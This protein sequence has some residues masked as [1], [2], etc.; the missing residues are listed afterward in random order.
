MRFSADSKLLRAAVRAVSVAAA[1][2][3]SKSIFEAVRLT[4]VVDGGV[5]LEATDLELAAVQSLRCEVSDAGACA[6]SVQALGAALKGL[7]GEVVGRLDGARLIIA[8]A[9]LTVEDVSA[10]PEVPAPPSSW[11]EVP[12]L[13]ARLAEA[14]VSCGREAARFV[15]NGIRLEDRYVIATDARRMYRAEVLD[16]GGR[17]IVSARLGKVAEEADGIAFEPMRV[18]LRV[19]GGYYAAREMEGQYPDHQQLVLGGDRAAWEVDAHALVEAC[20]SA[21]RMLKGARYEAVRLTMNVACEVRASGPAG[22]YRREVAARHLGGAEE[23]TIGFN[24][25]FLADA[26]ETTGARTVSFDARNPAECAALMVGT[27]GRLAVLMP[28]VLEE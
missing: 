4:A 9:A 12:G 1:R 7:R 15:L 14:A 26:M 8:D 25:S 27:E 10:F 13:G 22:E 11:R 16:F 6:V 21:A 3:S 24:P 2:R 5:R 17:S 20:R 19:P 18:Y 28:V 23:V